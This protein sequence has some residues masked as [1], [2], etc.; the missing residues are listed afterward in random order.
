VV[1]AAAGYQRLENQ[2][3]RVEIHQGGAAG[4][5]TFKWSR[6]NGSV[7]SGV[8]GIDPAAHSI[9]I[10]DPGRDAYLSFAAGQW[11]EITS[12][13]VELNPDAGPGILVRLTTPT[14]GTLLTYDPLTV[15]GPAIDATTFKPTTKVR[16]WDADTGMV[17]TDQ[18]TWIALEGGVQVRFGG[19]DTYA[20]GD[21]WL[22]PA[23]AVTAL[24]ASGTIEWPQ[25]AG[26]PALRPRAGIRHHYCLLGTGLVA[27]D[28][29]KSVTDC[30]RVF[31]PL[32]AM[33]SLYYAGGD[34]QEAMPDYTLPVTTLLPA[35]PEPLRAGVTNGDVPV[36]G[37]TVR[38]AVVA[39]GGMLLPPAPPVGP[40]P[41][42][43]PTIDVRTGSDGIASCTWQLTNNTAG[44]VQTVRAT[45]L[46]G[47]GVPTSTPIWYGATLSVA[48]QVAIDPRNCTKLAPAKTVQDAIDKLCK[49]QYL[50]LRYLGGDSQEGTVNKPLPCPLS[51]G[52]EDET[53]QPRPNVQVAFDA[54]TAGDILLVP[55]TA[56]AGTKV[57]AT[58]DPNGVAQVNWTLGAGGQ[59]ECHRVDAHLQS[60]PPQGAALTIHFDATIEQG[61]QRAFPVVKKI[62][63][64]NDR[65]LTLAALEKD[66]LTVTISTA[67]DP[68]TVNPSTFIVTAEVPDSFTQVDPKF[69]FRRSIIL[70]GTVKVVDA[71]NNTM[72]RFDPVPQLTRLLVT[73]WL[74]QQLGLFGEHLAGPGIRCRVVLKGNFISGKEGPPLDGNTFG[75]KDPAGPFL[76]FDFSAP[77][78]G[79][80][81]GD[82]ESW[83]WL[84]AG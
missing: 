41:G 4:T 53:G 72:F 75:K 76:D 77:G 10:R 39:G 14:E 23:R 15:I 51:V 68:D 65:T 33:T 45:L 18:A 21:Y 16:R 70:G 12:D 1:P 57:V 34:G 29:S 6:D 56:L 82:F 66:G 61:A 11:V 83:F 62:T 24:S 55:G 69:A 80:K 54:L 74:A 58:T 48:A 49:Q 35:L 60:P 78:D 44:V 5:A 79:I 7:V 2:L 8:D 63:W 46:D 36:T 43:A 30:R 13:A 64:L 25:D 28:S 42:P 26:G 40:A 20:T 31:P 47:T 50:V 81:G 37:A 19:G 73:G 71:P 32:T 38:F 17:T 3:Y 52:V 59:S 84:V 9:T 22:I 67:M 27:A